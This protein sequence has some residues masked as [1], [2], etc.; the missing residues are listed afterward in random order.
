MMILRESH[1]QIII[2]DVLVVI[3]VVVR[4]SSKESW[5]G[6][7]FIIITILAPMVRNLEETKCGI[8]S[9][10]MVYYLLNSLPDEGFV[11]RCITS[12]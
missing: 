12:V 3:W 2:K 10:T 6:Q 7:Q 11:C 4:E 9:K 1:C 5:R 8:Y